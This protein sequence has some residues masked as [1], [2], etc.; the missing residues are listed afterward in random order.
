MQLHNTFDLWKIKGASGT[1]NIT[2]IRG[3]NARAIITILGK[4]H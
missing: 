2:E 1:R 3:V 4:Y